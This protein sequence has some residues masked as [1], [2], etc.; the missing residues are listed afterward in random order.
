MSTVLKIDDIR[1]DGGTQPR[2]SIDYQAVQ[3]YAD[4]MADGAKFPPVIV[5]YDGTDYWL[6]DGFHRVQAALVAG[7]AE[8]AGEVHQ[9]TLEDAQWHSFGANKANGI[10][11]DNRD[12]QRA[13][14]AA[15]THPKSQG[16]SDSAI[17]RHVGVD[18]VTVARHREKLT[19]SCEIH[20]I[21][22]RTASRGGTTY[23]INT[24]NIGRE[25]QQPTAFTCP[26]CGDVFSAEVWHC[27][28]CGHHWRM[29]QTQCGN[30]GREQSAV[31]A[32]PS[33]TTPDTGAIA[34]R[35]RND[36][37][38]LAAEWALRVYRACAEITACQLTAKNL[39][40][41]IRRSDSGERLKKQLE[42]TNE[43][44]ETVLADLA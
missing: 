23:Q 12:K 26:T 21:E 10:R 30:C 29:H 16:L 9:G 14:R 36:S 20:K 2:T 28:T 32:P 22:T 1:T 8:I 39:A 17:A 35:E 27:A 38:R 18:H 41:S 6:A 40:A 25:K 5:F 4:A 24:A 7:R 42:T 3:D 34:Q 19:A 31:P 44:I 43:F 13:V 33:E 15:L 11:R 37:D